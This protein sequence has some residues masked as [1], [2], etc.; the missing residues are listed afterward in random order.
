[1]A[2]GSTGR[3][4]APTAASS[5]PRAEPPMR[6]TILITG[7]S[8]GFGLSTARP[9]ADAGHTVYTGTREIVGSNAAQADGSLLR[10]DTV[11]AGYAGDPAAA[12]PVPQE[13]IAAEAA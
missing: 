11:G 13:S 8:S 4:F 1:M 9:L 7:A 12:G 5:D 10:G 2:H 3:F 6:Q